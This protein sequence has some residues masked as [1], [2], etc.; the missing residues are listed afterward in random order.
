MPLGVCVILGSGG[1]AGGAGKKSPGANEALMEGA[2]PGVPLP[3]FLRAGSR[4]RGRLPCDVC[5]QKEGK[6][7]ETKDKRRSVPC[8]APLALPSLKLLG[9]AAVAPWIPGSHHPE[10]STFLP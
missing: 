6:K 2:A 7:L 5:A 8:A 10:G 4:S 9:D 3:A 1:A